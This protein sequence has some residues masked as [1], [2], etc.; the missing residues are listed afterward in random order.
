[1][2]IDFFRKNKTTANSQRL[3]RSGY[4]MWP[5]FVPRLPF[6]KTANR[7]CLLLLIMCPVMLTA[8]NG[9]KVSNLAVEAGT[10]TFSVS[11][12]NTGMPARW[13]D[14]V[15]VFVDHNKN[16]AM[17]R[18]PLVP[19]ATLTAT[20]APGVGKVVEVSGNNKGVWVIGNARSAGNFSATVKLL[21]ANA[22]IAGACAY[23]SNYPPVGDYKSSTLLLF[24]G[25][26]MY[27]LV[28]KH[29][30][31]NIIVRKS[32]SLYSIPANYTLQSFTDKTGAPGIIKCVPM[33][34]NINFSFP[35]NIAK[36]KQVSFVIT[37]KPTVP[38][39][40]AITYTWT[41]PNFTPA[42]FSGA[43]NLAYTAVAPDLGVYP[44]TLTGSS[45]GYCDLTITNNVTV[46]DCINPA[47]FT[48]TASASG[49]C[50]GDAGVAFGLSGTE[51]GR[52]YQ[53]YNGT[54]TV[55]T[56]LSGTGSAATFSGMFNTAG[57]YTAQ[58]I[59]D[60]AYCAASM[61][62][63]HNISENPLPTAPTISSSGD[64]C[65]NTGDIKFT[66]TGYTGKLEWVSN[67]GGAESGNTVTFT[68]TLTGVKAVTARSSQTYTNAPTCYSAKVSK[69]ATVNSSLDSPTGVGNSRCGAGTVTISATSSS[70]GAVIEWYANAT[71]GAAL[72][73]GNSYTPS[74]T[75]STTYYAQAKNSAGCLSAL[76]RTA[77]VATIY[78]APTAPTGLSS[79]V[80]TICNGVE[81]SMILTATGGAVGSG[82]VY[83]WGIG[84]TV[85][86][87]PLT[88]AT[89]TANTCTVSPSEATTYW[90]RLKG[91]TSCSNATG[92]VT[93]AIETHPA[94]TAGTILT[95]ST[96]TKAGTNPNVTASNV[97]AASGGG[98]TI[99]YEWRRSGTSSKTLSGSNTTSY[100]L[101]GD[102]TNY[103][104]IGTYSFNRYARNN[105]CNTSWVAATGTYTLVVESAS[106][107]GIATTLCT[108]C[109]WSDST[110]VDCY[111]T[112]NHVNTSSVW[113]GNGTRYYIGASGSGSDKNGRVN[114]SAISSISS[115]AVQRCKNLGTGWYLPAYEELVNM[116]TGTNNDPLNGRPGAGILTGSYHWSSTELYDNRGRRTSTR[117]QDQG[118]AI[119]VNTTGGLTNDTKSN[120]WGVRCAWRN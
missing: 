34:G 65:Q 115:S 2:N 19:G 43:Y 13:S 18:V 102:D 120:V 89:T 67:G 88:P 63:S 27:E 56:V 48:L 112:T 5:F 60:D 17:E 114:T 21:T 59:I 51:N 20:S 94:F 106:P 26:P 74:I 31:G 105:V 91:T 82:A 78:T 46:S 100:A 49:F 72:H 41:A 35:S 80:E 58:S 73:T 101:S 90:V 55:G 84:G 7:Y 50:A 81:T 118:G 10:V 97:T 87:N 93:T 9:V 8:Q 39:V 92:G 14:S 36:N 54:T 103:S 12:K 42:S 79:N 4:F 32:D 104:T 62:A 57:V 71:G 77:V 119:L 109:C 38:D 85:G 70:P 111:V 66:A 29:T 40:A 30:D 15:W 61:N 44:V 116:S 75:G 108:A 98:G 76:P 53:L 110:W 52:K 64:V 16:G 68:S 23:A 69:S 96:T 83:E 107:P 117:T 6:T 47:T 33:T 3:T 86:S 113:S 1:M 95:A 45:T 25:T 24:T 37:S 11:W 22:H 99:E 28:L